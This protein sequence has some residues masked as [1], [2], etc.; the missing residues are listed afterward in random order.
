MTVWTV[1]WLLWLLAFCLIEGL[2][3]RN[4]VYGD[5][6]SEHVWSWFSI[7]GRGSHWRARRFVLLALLAWL[8]A[9]FLTGGQ[10]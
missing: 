7:K 6:L 1:A 2:A 3:L 4:N 8:V 5:T 9:H 10:F